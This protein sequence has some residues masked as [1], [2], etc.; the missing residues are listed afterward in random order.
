MVSYCLKLTTVPAHAYD[1]TVSR[2]YQEALIRCIEQTLSWNSFEYLAIRRGRPIVPCGF[3]VT[4]GC[5][6]RRFRIILLSQLH[7]LPMRY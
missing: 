2:N 7:P 3:I 5:G 4:Y 1:A 6:I